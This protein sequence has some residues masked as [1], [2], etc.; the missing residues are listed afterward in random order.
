[1]LRQFETLLGIFPFSKL[2]SR[3]PVL[4][5]Y[6]VEMSEPAL[7]ER[8]FA[9]GGVKADMAAAIVAASRDFI[10]SDCCLEV[11]AY[12]DLWQWSGEWKL[13]PAAVTLLCFG[14][15]FAND[16]GDHLRIELGPDFRFLPMPDVEASLR[17][18]QSNLRSLLHLVSDIEKGLPVQR[19]SIWSESGVNFAELLAETVSRLEIN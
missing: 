4:R 1:M 5:V 17:M 9:P 8:E 3:G 18:G 15:G 10:E 19:R 11:E 2:A 7:L 6:A 16:A 12:W 14:P 13:A